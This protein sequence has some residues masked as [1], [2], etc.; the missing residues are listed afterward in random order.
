MVPM[1]VTMDGNPSGLLQVVLVTGCSE[2]VEEVFHADEPQDVMHTSLASWCRIA[3]G[4]LHCVVD[5]GCWMAD[6]LERQP[7]HAVHVAPK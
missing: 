1:L 6:M 4:D 5:V 2:A 7:G 3:L